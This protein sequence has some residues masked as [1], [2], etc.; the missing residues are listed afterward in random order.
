MVTTK[1]EA[2]KP[3]AKATTKD[4]E[5][6]TEKSDAKT[7]TATVPKKKAAAK[8]APA[9]TAAK[10]PAK[11]PAKAATKSRS[12]SKAV[13]KNEQIVFDP[14]ADRSTV[15]QQAIENPAILMTLIESLS[16]EARRIRQF[17]AAAI[18][19]LSEKAPEALVIHIA[20]ITD[21]LHRPEA[22]TRWECL[23]VLTRVVELDPPACDDA[24]IGAESSLYDEES[25]TARLA[26][27]RFLCAYGAI[28]SKRS[29]RVW[30]LLDEAIQCY[31]GDPEFQDMLVSVISFAGGHVSKD[32][33]TSL[34]TRMGFDATNGKGVLQRRAVQI[35]DLCKK[36]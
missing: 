23:D 31:H 12:R 3:A 29:A 10:A 5:K 16:T 18:G 33:K 36:K 13:A 28:D 24:L 20:P 14:T 22:Q 27:V 17:S 35:V 15:A 21:A 6:S 7:A 30:P 25:G 8:V 1:K 2:T 34:A 32:V 9:K 11:K 4:T 26:A 19:V